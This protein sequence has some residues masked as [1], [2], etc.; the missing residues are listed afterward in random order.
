MKTLIKILTPFVILLTGLLRA[1]SFTITEENDFW[2]DS[3]NDYTQGLELEWYGSPGVT[4]DGQYV[5]RDGISLRNHFYTPS[6]ITISENQP[7][8]RPW[9]GLTAITL[10]RQIQRKNFME[11]RDIMVGAVGEWSYSDKIQARFH[12]LIDSDKP[13]GWR[14]QIKNEPAV[15]W[16]HSIIYPLVSVGNPYRVS[17][18]L[19]PYTGY[20]VGNVAIYGDVGV[21]T[22]VGY[23]MPSQRMT[24]INPTAVKTRPVLYGFGRAQARYYVHNIFIDGS[25]FRDGPEMDAVPFVTDYQLGV[26]AGVTDLCIWNKPYDI[27]ATYAVTHRSKEYRGQYNSNDFGTARLSIGRNF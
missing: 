14:H 15:N 13:M 9:G 20:G 3:D 5:K 4:A 11:Q 27:L 25:L 17:A 8:D 22:R 7:D 10:K 19:A 26:T 2:V 16:M 21:I 18:D 23:N 12:E 24:M 1:Q 6:D